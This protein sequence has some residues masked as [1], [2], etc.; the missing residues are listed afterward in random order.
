LKENKCIIYYIIKRKQGGK[1]GYRGVRGVGLA[2]D[3]G[4]GE[5]ADRVGEN[6]VDRILILYNILILG[7]ISE[8]IGV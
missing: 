1:K 4:V 7:H 3:D 6:V 5:R 2:L 8:M